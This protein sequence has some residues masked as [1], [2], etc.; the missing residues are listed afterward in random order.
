MLKHLIFIVGVIGCGGGGG[1]S[2]ED[3]PDEIEG[4]QCDRA[5]ACEGIADRATCE[6]AVD[7]ND[8]EFGALQAAVKDGTIK[9]DSGK[10]AD[11]ADSFGSTDCSFPG[12]HEDNPCDDVFT[13]TVATGGACV[14]DLQCANFGSCVT[15]PSCDPETTCCTGTCMGM[16][17]ESPIGGPCGN[18]TSFCGFDAFCKT[19]ATGGAGTCTALI[20]GEG[21][22]CDE[23]DA[24][25][26]PLYCNLNF[27]TGTGTCK[28]AAASNA[29]CSRM[30]LIPCADSRDYCDPTMLKCVRDAA[31]GAACPTGVQCVGFASCI[32]GTCVADIAAGGAC[33]VDTGADC[34]G[35]LE[36][37]GGTCKLP[38]VGM[39][40]MLPP[41]S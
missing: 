27:Q 34:A 24:C 40:C 12:F 11:C 3:L 35:N 4:A 17:T 30:D 21:T 15:M 19:P 1:V 20:A 18:E 31:V 38:P 9:Y 22:A 6:A 36:C 23:I 39:T 41:S 28:K 5:V 29:T 10:A 26:N 8:A 32:A 37:I 14:I 16:A 2:V 7:L 33:S 13:G 25:V